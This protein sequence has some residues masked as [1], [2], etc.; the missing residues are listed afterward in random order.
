MGWEMHV[1]QQ[2]AAPPLLQAESSELRHF[3]NVPREREKGG[4]Q[5]S[6]ERGH[7]DKDISRLGMA[8]ANQSSSAS[9]TRDLGSSGGRAGGAGR[10]VAWAV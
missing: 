1:V 7:D 6:A 9:R 4:G 3:P 8:S 10:P 5:Q 2:G